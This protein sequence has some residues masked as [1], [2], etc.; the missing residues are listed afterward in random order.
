M[1]SREHFGFEARHGRLFGKGD[2]KYVVLDLLREK[3]SHG[4]EIIRRLEERFHGHYAPSAGIVYPTL[5]MLEDLGYV[6]VNQ[7]DGKKIYTITEQG[8]GFLEEQQHVVDETRERM[9]TWWSHEG[10]DEVH[11]MVDELRDLGR[12]LRQRARWINAEK[13]RRIHE[14]ISRAC[15]E[16]EAILEGSGENRQQAEM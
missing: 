4:Y 12:S 9:R 1:S 2:F 13:L 14:V 3:P 10:R 15:R 7:Q 6:T 5:Q 16:I 11:E 8:L